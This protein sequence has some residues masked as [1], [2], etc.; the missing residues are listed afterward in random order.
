MSQNQSAIRCAS[1]NALAVLIACAFVSQS[2][3]RGQAPAETKNPA[4]Q[5]APDLSTKY[6][7]I[8]RYSVPGSKPDPQSL[9]QYR[10]GIRET[11]E[12][13]IEKPQGAPDRVRET[14]QTIFSERAARI[15]QT[16]EVTD[17]IRRYA[18]FRKTPDPFK[19]T[20]ERP[21]EGL[22]LWYHAG[23]GVDPRIVNLTEGRQLHDMEY[24]VISRQ[25]FAPDLR[26]LLPP[27]PSLVGDS[28]RIPKSAILAMIRDRPEGGEGLTGKLQSVRKSADGTQLVAVMNVS[29]RLIL[30]LV[31]YGGDR[32]TGVNGELLFAFSPAPT[33]ESPPAGGAAREPIVNARGAITE[34]RFVLRSTFLDPSDPDGRRRIIVDHIIDL[35]RRALDTE[36]ELLVPPAPPAPTEPNS[37]L[38]YDDPAG[39]F[40][41]RHPQ[42]LRL[43]PPQPGDPSITFVGLSGD[44]VILNFQEKTGRAE[45]D[46]RSRDPADYRKNLE[47]QWKEDGIDVLPG[48]EGW[49]PEA[50]WADVKMKVYHLE[51]VMRV[52]EEQGKSSKRLYFDFYLALCD[53]GD[54]L[55]FTATTDADPPTAFRKQAE[56]MLR[57]LKVATSP[58]GRA[59]APVPEGTAK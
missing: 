40:R 18:T 59:V 17:T 29:G 5:A 41:I 15:L 36:A 49:L 10:V 44:A 54:S 16:G 12:R 46:R 34:L 20:D 33:A 13:I 57:S 43:Q 56:Q 11:I 45:E 1:R 37:W 6:R 2:T 14:Y 27:L 25:I 53:R 31:G 22:T 24:T 39:R 42:N 8:E 38:T 32:V 23:N 55:V 4:G 51:A 19:P 52:P 47:A 35:R 3:S 21:L 50:D 58:R 30:P 48:R 28:W 9:G 7:F 26:A